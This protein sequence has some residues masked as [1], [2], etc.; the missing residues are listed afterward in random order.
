MKNIFQLIFLFSLIINAL[1]A[2]SCSSITDA[3][4]CKDDCEWVAAV[5]KACE[6]IENVMTEDCGA[7]K[8]DSDCP[9]VKSGET[10]VCEWSTTVCV[11]KTSAIEGLCTNAAADESTCTKVKKG[12][13]VLCE[14]TPAS[15]AKCVTKPVEFGATTIK[16]KSVKGKAV[17]ITIA[18]VEAEK[19]QL[20]TGDT[21][22]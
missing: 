16:L 7:A 14:F 22:I 5:T 4:K 8:S 15:P 3:S 21:T 2:D 18:P 12:D 9:N 20:L 6:A 17:G 19:N 13:T 1:S 11:A 10:A